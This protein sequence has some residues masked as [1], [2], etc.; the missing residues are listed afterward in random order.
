MKLQGDNLIF[1]LVPDDIRSNQYSILK[2]SDGGL[3]WSC[4]YAS[5]SKILRGI[6]FLNDN[7]GFIVGDDGVMLKTVDAGETWI[8]MPGFG[9][10][11]FS[12]NF[13]DMNTGYAVGPSIILKTTDGRTSWNVINYGV[14][15]ILRSVWFVSPDKGFI[16]ENGGV[17]G[18]NSI[19]RTTNGGTTWIKLV[20]GIE[21]DIR[22]LFFLDENN[23][24]AVGYNEEIL[25]T[26][27]GGVTWTEVHTGW[28]Y[29][30]YAV[31]FRDLNTGIAIISD[32]EGRELAK[33]E[34][35]GG[36]G[37]TDVGQLH[38]GIYFVRVVSENR[39]KTGRFVK[40]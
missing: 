2:T 29:H 6:D 40:L 23:G 15:S 12:V 16:I 37:Q 19:Y 36:K 4:R 38:P 24:F 1:F 10:T 26:N 22:A 20:T 11:L 28:N 17:A 18:Y 27:N 34:L 35:T 9:Y 7:K 25:K 31:W 21:S 3:S 13:P 33:V 5:T 39:V 30:F 14:F 8:E 32:L